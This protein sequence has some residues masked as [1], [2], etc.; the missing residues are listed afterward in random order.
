MGLFRKLSQTIWHCQYHIIWTP[1]YYYRMLTGDLTQDIENSVRSFSER[2]SCE[3]SEI[4]VQADHVHLLAMVPLKVS[5]S[6]CLRTIKSLTAIRI[7]SKYK[8][9]RQKPY[10]VNHFW[11]RKIS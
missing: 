6:G 10:W 2:L 4:N 9:L 5:I 3:I 8:T 1:K 11:S 7:L